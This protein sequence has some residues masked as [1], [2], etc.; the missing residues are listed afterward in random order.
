MIK[1]HLSN[2]Q[3]YVKKIRNGLKEHEFP[4]ACDALWFCYQSVNVQISY[5]MINH[6]Q[7][8]TLLVTLVFN[9]FS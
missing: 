6:K 9:L 2:D 1:K 7:F 4:V 8:E 3:T 5:L